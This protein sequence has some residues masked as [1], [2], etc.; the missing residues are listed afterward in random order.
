MSTDRNVL[1]GLI[2][3]LV[4]GGAAFAFAA[5]GI[6]AE[7]N[8][9]AARAA[10]AFLLFVGT[11][12]VL[13][14]LYCFFGRPTTHEGKERKQHI[15]HGFQLAGG[16]LLGFVLMAAVVGSSQIAFGIVQSPRLSRIAACLI[17]M[18]SLGL[19]FSL[20]RLWARHF[21]GWVGYS[22][23]NGLLMVSSG[24]LVNNPAILVPRWWS[25]SATV[26]FLT[27]ALVSVRFAK[28]YTLNVIDKAALMTWLLAFVFAV[29]VESA[30]S[31]YHAQFGLGAV[32]IGTLA[33]VAA[34]WYQRA[35]RHHRHR[36]SVEPVVISE[37][38]P[39][40]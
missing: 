25:V 5:F 34:W 29:D 27:G 18:A 39:Y 7:A 40:H 37:K 26:L 36:G 11:A 15:V 8:T 1:G 28:N 4:F 21:A 35:K 16:I 20:I 38:S 14:G 31:L 33:L 13:A 17:T 6:T 12:L 10:V 23:L 30:H 3:A 22:V 24:H 9:N 32:L 19:I 2:A